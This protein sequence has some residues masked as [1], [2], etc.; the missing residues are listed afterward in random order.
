MSG[1]LTAS[2]IISAAS[3]EEAYFEEAINSVFG[4]TLDDFELIVVDDGLSE[5]NRAFLA[6][7]EDPRLTVLVNEKNIGQSKSVNK[8]LKIA[9]GTFVIRMDADDVML[10]TRIADEV[11]YMDEHADVIVAGALAIRSNDRRIIPRVYPDGDCF[12]VGLLFANDMVH[13][14]M[15]IR[16]EMA[17]ERGL[18]YDEDFLYA[19]DYKF[20]ADALDCGKVGFL[21]KPV[22]VYRMHPGQ[23]LNTKTGQRPKFSKRARQRAF[24]HFGVELSDG[25]ADEL[26]SFVDG[27]DFRGFG[28]CPVLRKKCCA[29]MGDDVYPL[30]AREL[31]FRAFKVGMRCI[32][33]KRLGMALGSG[34]FWRAVLRFWYWPFYRKSLQLAK[35]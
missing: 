11:A 28:I 9:R 22:L 34:E 3:T 8:A 12:A 27:R 31:S 1:E 24:T 19:Q 5:E 15:V 14:T 20:W 7:I 17:L 26:F 32:S 6:S 16:R 4:Q 25:E 10:P 33:G 2:V 18:W 23:I 29:A 35:G 21:E 30:F 13:P